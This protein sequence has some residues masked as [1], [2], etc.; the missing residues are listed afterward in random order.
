[1]HL[2][3]SCPVEDPR[4]G[5][6]RPRSLSVGLGLR[7]EDSDRKGGAGS[8]R[9]A[10]LR[11]DEAGVGLRLD[12]AELAKKLP[13]EVRTE[14]RR[15]SLSGDCGSPAGAAPVR[16]AAAGEGKSGSVALVEI[17]VTNKGQRDLTGVQV[18]A[19]PRMRKTNGGSW[20]GKPKKGESARSPGY[21]RGFLDGVG[22]RKKEYQ[23]V[24][25]GVAAAG[26]APACEPL[27]IPSGFNF[28]LIGLKREITVKAD[29]TLS[30]PVVFVVANAA[31]P[32][33][34]RIDL[35]GVMEAIRDALLKEVDR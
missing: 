2:G 15:F 25:S 11:A 19:S 14:T 5:G 12:M 24:L 6:S 4:R 21:F 33:K 10:T 7:A 35:A 3:I 22:P 27:I 28:G 1:V 9:F 23:L 31:D 30:L 18:L 8:E 17:K 26:G 20:P 13:V 32:A 34:P 29:S 16:L